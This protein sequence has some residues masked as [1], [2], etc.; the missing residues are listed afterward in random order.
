MAVKAQECHALISYFC[1]KFKEKYG[2]EPVVNRHS[3]RWG[4]DSILQGMSPSEARQLIDYYFTTT[5]MKRHNLDWFFYNYDKLQE[6]R[7]ES[8]K[9]KERR[10]KMRRESEQRAKEWRERF[11]NKGVTE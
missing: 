7:V 9:D 10:E 2:M 4:F 5:Q 8:D 1:K 3:S 6:G 11:G